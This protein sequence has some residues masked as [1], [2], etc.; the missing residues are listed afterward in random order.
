MM[1]PTILIQFKANNLKVLSKQGGEAFRL[2][3]LFAQSVEK[4]VLLS[5]FWQRD[6]Y[7]YTFASKF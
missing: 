2:N 5:A 6:Q 1:F 4:T 3:I 7:N